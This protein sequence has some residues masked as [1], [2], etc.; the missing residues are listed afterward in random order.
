MKVASALC[1][2]AFVHAMELRSCLLVVSD[3]S[4]INTYNS[5]HSY[6]DN[7]GI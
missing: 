2:M 6:V 5:K 1:K 3:L 7:K 4:S